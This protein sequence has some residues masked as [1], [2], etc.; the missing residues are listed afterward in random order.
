MKQGE[1]LKF[2]YSGLFQEVKIRIFQSSQQGSKYTISAEADIKLPIL[3]KSYLTDTEFDA[4]GWLAQCAPYEKGAKPWRVE[5]N[6]EHGDVHDPISFFLNLHK[7]DWDAE[8]VK[9]AIGNKV[10]ELDVIQLKNGYEVKRRDKDQ[11][12]IVRKDSVGI[13]ALEIPLPV[14][15]TVSIKRV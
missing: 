2:R 1:E 13:V 4:S 7:G 5:R 9:L 11:K 3:K 15:G 14:I 6:P 12:L 10:V 8:T